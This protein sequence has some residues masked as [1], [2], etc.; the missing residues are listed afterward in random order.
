M[1]FIDI[2]RFVVLGTLAMMIWL[3]L[4]KTVIAFLDDL[5]IELRRWRERK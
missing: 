2:A 4:S 5:E 3:I 1:T